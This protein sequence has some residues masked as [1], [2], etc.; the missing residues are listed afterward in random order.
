MR[1][2]VQVSVNICWKQELVQTMLETERYI[3]GVW[4]RKQINRA[5]NKAEV[6]DHVLIQESRKFCPTECVRCSC[7]GCSLILYK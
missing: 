7:T 6:V 4:K 3:S 5:I 1:G 2:K